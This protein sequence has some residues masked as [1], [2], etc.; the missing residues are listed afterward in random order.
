MKTFSKVLLL[1]LLFSSIS[2]CKKGENYCPVAKGVLGF[3]SHSNEYDPN[4]EITLEL[5]YDEDFR[6]EIMK[7]RLLFNFS[8]PLVFINDKG[9]RGVDVVND[10]IYTYKLKD[11]ENAPDSIQVEGYG[12]NDCGRSEVARTVIRFKK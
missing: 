1:V 7:D 2:S 6:M 3:K 10:P 9:D 4:D 5:D 12:F 11:T 8:V